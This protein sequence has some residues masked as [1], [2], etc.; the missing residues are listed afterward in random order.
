MEL[1]CALTEEAART[2]REQLGP[3]EEIRFCLAGDLTLGRHFGESHIAV[4]DTRI[5]VCDSAGDARALDLSA[6]D[7]VRV[8]ELFGSGRLVAVVNGEEQ[9]L[10]YYSKV[11]VPQFAVLGRAINDLIGGRTPKLPDEEE[12]AICE[13][14]YSPLPE[15]GATCPRCVRR[16]RVFGRLLR[17]VQPYGG[18]VAVVVLTTFVTA[19]TRMAPPYVTKVIVDHVIGPK[20]LTH[21]RVWVGALLACGVL[22]LA[23]SLVGGWLSSWTAA[24]VVADLR[25]QLHAHL[26]RLKLQ[27][28]NQRDSGQLVARVMH[29]TVGLQHFLIDGL[30]YLLVNAVSFVGIAAILLVLDWRL[31]LLAFVPVP[32]LLGGGGA[33]SRRL[34]NLLHKEGAST[35]SVHSLLRES[36]D[37]IRSVKALT[38]EDRR[39]RQFAGTNELLFQARVSIE[40]TWIGFFEVMAFVMALGL[41]GVWYFAA[42]RIAAG[43]EALTLGDLV[44]FVGYIA[45]FYMPLRW[46]G[47]IFNW[48]THA[49]AGAERIF[50][51]LDSNPEVYDSPDAV[52]LPHMRGAIEFSDVRFSYE[53]GNEVIKG[54]SFTVEPGEMIGLVGKSGAGKSTII[55]LICRFFDV[56]A[57]EIRIDGVS[58]R[59]LRLADLRRQVGMVMQAPFLFNASILENIRYGRPDATFEDVVRAAR[60]ANAHDFTVSKEDGYDTV[61]GE[62][63]AALS[64]GEQ[65]RLMIARAILHDPA[66]L[67]L[68]E[69]TSSVDSETERAIQEA[70]GNLIRG[71]TTIAIAHRLATLRNADRLIVVDDG[72]IAEMGTHD[73][74]LENGGAY[75]RLVEIQSELSRLR[76]T[77]WAE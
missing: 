51:V 21:L 11:C 48:M 68:D 67:I 37:G 27:Y 54:V 20:D 25:S 18:W 61:I 29:D 13:R 66:I 31:A 26:Q 41:A 40:R 71:R 58:V 5:A 64:G 6:V 35:G 24:R 63:G 36:I 8:D 33:L 52:A 39:S 70:I 43:D 34:I 74:L 46:F 4:G 10:V 30:P 56:D 16:L 1:Q 49:L 15:R 62:G 44:A 73:E 60:A 72:R 42:R 76:Q 77:V 55:S 57:G 59:K 12:R 75:A 65:Q 22:V 53:R 7:E 14:C 69:A 3:D 32:F 2:L 45:L 50:A 28:F 9:A 38:Q 17:L 47:A 19:G 23:A